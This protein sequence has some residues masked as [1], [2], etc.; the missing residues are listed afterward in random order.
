LMFMISL[1]FISVTST[2][3]SLGFFKFIIVLPHFY[4]HKST[5]TLIPANP[6]RLAHGMSREGLAAQWL[7]AVAAMIGAKVPAILRIF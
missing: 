5:R 2:V 6:S 4:R 7:A 1:E 3:Q